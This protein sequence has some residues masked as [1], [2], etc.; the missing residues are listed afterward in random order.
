MR[1]VVD[2]DTAATRRTMLRVDGDVS[3]Q[4]RRPPR[5]H[6]ITDSGHENVGM[7]EKAAAGRRNAL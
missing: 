6:D 1:V 4:D 5:R 2:R 3:W 7:A